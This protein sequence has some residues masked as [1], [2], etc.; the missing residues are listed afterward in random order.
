MRRRSRLRL[1]MVTVP[2]RPADYAA[3]GVPPPPDT[4]RGPATPESAREPA[5]PQAPAPPARL[6][7]RAVPPPDLAAASE[8]V[9]RLLDPGEIDLSLLPRRRRTAIFL[10]GGHVCAIGGD[11]AALGRSLDNTAVLL[12]PAV[13]R[14]H[15]LLLRED[16]GTWRVVNIST[17]N[18]LL[19]GEMVLAPG[20]E[21]AL[22][23]GET[24]ALGHS[25]VQLLAPGG[26]KEERGGRGGDAEDAEDAEEFSG[27]GTRSGDARVASGAR[28]VREAE[29]PVFVGAHGMRPARGERWAAGDSGTRV[30]GLGVTMEFALRRR[31]NTRAFALLAALA[32]V[33]ALACSVVTLGAAAL[34]GADA[35]STYGA[36]HVLAALAIPLAPSLGVGLLVA[37]LDRYEREPP[38]VLLGAFLW[39][40]LIAIAPVLLLEHSLTQALLAGI[41][42]HGLPAD[43]TRAL[44]RALTA[45]LTE[46]TVKGAGLLVLLV[47]LRDEFDNV[48]DGVLYGM[49]V[50]AGFALVE[51]FAYFAQTPRG[52]LPF[53][54]AGRIVLGWLGH[55]TFTAIF[56]AALGFARETRDRATAWMA[57]LLGFCLAVLLH[58]AFDAVTF[59]ADA[60]A[61]HGVAANTVQ[62][63]VGALALAYVPLFAEQTALGTVLLAAL[64]R[65]AAVVREFLAAEVLRG[66]VTPDE[67][68]LLQNATLRARVERRLLV[69]LGPRAYLTARA[70]HQAAIGLAFRAWHVANGDPPKPGA[71]QP[72]D[73]YR[74]RIVRLRASLARQLAAAYSALM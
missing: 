69:G 48:T 63:I 39:G 36:G 3:A 28:S 2:P 5:P 35:L 16:D 40:A 54:I 66:S 51:N 41:T 38:P 62:F 52:D 64:R 30:L 34:I 57:S 14:E 22:R 18:P 56:G 70:L 20:T 10:N 24:L 32:L 67:Y 43:L 58:T 26:G 46:E 45:G 12:D 74:A 1:P 17:H 19:A 11:V 23:A 21:G 13:S 33:A 44:T 15:A 29:G 47:A 53:L 27:R 25:A 42:A 71:L 50:G 37:L 72:E 4:P 65:E 60:L 8:A 61:Q 9:L 73:A 68:V 49:L 7:L 59:G 6:T 31:P 55:S